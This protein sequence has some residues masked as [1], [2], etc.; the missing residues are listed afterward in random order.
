MTE[1]KKIQE[2]VVKNNILPKNCDYHTQRSIRNSKGQTGKI[3]V[4]AVNGTAMVEYICP[5]CSNYGYIEQPWK[6]PFAAKCEKCG[7]KMGVPKMK[8]AF[9][10]EQKKG[11]S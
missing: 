1:F 2:Y 5:D 4:L 6:R 3:R 11:K 10:K 7:F 9:K 8:Q